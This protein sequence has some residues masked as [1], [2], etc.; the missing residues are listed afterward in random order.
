MIN[1]TEAY[2]S[3]HAQ[4]F[5]DA[6]HAVDLH[7]IYE[8]FE[9]YLQRG[10]TVLDAGCGSG[11]DVVY[12]LSQGYKVEAFDATA[13]MVELARSYSKSTIEQKRFT[14]VTSVNAY[15][16]IWSCASL[17]HVPKAELALVC[18]RFERA[19]KAKGV[20]YLSFRY[21]ESE[22]LKNGRHFS[23][24][25]PESFRAFIAPFQ[26]LK[27]LAIWQSA[28]RRKE[29]DEQWLNVLLQRN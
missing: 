10:A 11:R 23:D 9:A 7:D 24:F 17:L 18:Q 26:G 14:D 19:L 29:R 25:T 2:Y 5:F 4:E 12:F 22:R 3:A 16:G 13:Q 6:T 20:W 21:G 8:K 1:Q 28:D 27:E 15:D